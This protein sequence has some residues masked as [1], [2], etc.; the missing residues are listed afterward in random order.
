MTV[1]GIAIFFGPV[2]LIGRNSANIFKGGKTYAGWVALF[3]L[4]VILFWVG[5]ILSTIT[6]LQHL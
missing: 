5:A 6:I 1:G 4:S 2:R 3:I